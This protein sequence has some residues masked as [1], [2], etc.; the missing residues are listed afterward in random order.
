[1]LPLPRASAG[2]LILF[3]RLAKQQ[4]NRETF[5]DAVLDVSTIDSDV[6]HVG[7][8]LNED[9]IVH[10]VPD[11][12]VCIQ[13]LQNAIKELRPDI[14]ELGVVDVGMEQKKRAIEYAI[15]QV[16]RAQYNDLFLPNCINSNKR[17]SFYC[18]QLVVFSYKNGSLRGK[19][20]FLSHQLN[21]KDK[22]GQISKFWVD[23]YQKRGIFTVP[24]N[25]LGSHPSKIRASPVVKLSAARYCSTTK[26]EKLSIPTNFL[27]TMHY[28]GGALSSLGSS[29]NS[30]K[31]FEPRS[32]KKIIKSNNFLL[33]FKA[34]F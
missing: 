20:P 5:E 4:S 17:H 10:A 16:N 11:K 24:Q 30:F 28:V 22:T 3:R 1:M 32:G 21:F 7:M 34:K 29:T 31:V 26:M 27:K 6:F 13:S 15:K 8:V 33:Y 23:Y 25:E 9:Q 19:S 12:G 2:D 18:C 14:V